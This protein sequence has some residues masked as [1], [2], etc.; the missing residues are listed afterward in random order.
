[1]F[2]TRSLP[3]LIDKR[4]RTVLEVLTK[5]QEALSIF[6]ELE[7][8]YEEDSHFQQEV[9]SKKT[10][11]YRLNLNQTFF[12]FSLHNMSLNVLNGKIKLIELSCNDISAKMAAEL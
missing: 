8:M 9:R 5:N 12:L 10:P 4:H 7:P 11:Y 2:D 1:M 6:G 3:K